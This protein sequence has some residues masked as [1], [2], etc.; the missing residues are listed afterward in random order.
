M[1]PTSYLTGN[2]NYTQTSCGC[3]R[4]IQAFLKTTK[5]GITEDFIIQFD[6]FEKFLF[7]HK[8]LTTVSGKNASQ[9]N[10][11]EYKQD[12]TYFYNNIQFEKLY[13]F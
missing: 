13:D 9:Y 4:K 7:L 2:G 10:L 8:Q 12:I 1:I 6:N 3:D 11:E 5:I